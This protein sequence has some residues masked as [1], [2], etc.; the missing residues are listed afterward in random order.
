MTQTR[1]SGREKQ[2]L[3]FL[4]V[5]ADCFRRHGDVLKPRLQAGSPTAWRDWRCMQSIMERLITHIVP[6][7][8]DK[9][10]VWLYRMMREGTVRVDLPGPAWRTDYT[11]IS[12]DDL[13][14]IVQ[15]AMAE[16][17][18]MCL[19]LPADV[20]KCKLRSTM[21]HLMPPMDVQPGDNVTDCEYAMV[22]WETI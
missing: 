8:T 14:L 21:L 7:M 1:M 15:A 9:D 16:K 18:P 6:T 5:L 19:A 4:G 11:I 20:K 13:K 22:D 17:C 2:A 12:T 10:C 3:A